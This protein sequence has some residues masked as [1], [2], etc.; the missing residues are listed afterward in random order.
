MT[1]SD[2]TRPNDLLLLAGKVLSLFMQAVTGFAAI[3]LAI[4]IPGIIIFQD[5]FAVEW[6]QEFPDATQAMPVWPLIGILLIVLALL[7]LVFFFFGKLRRIIGTVG[8]GDPFAP[9]NATRLTEM[10][11]L[12]LGTQILLV[13]AA[14]LALMLSKFAEEA[15][16]LDVTIDAGLDIEGILM[17]VILFILARVF[18]HGAAMRDDLEGTV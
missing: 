12:L 15:E 10:A 18:R 4:V 16:H 5:S 14:G 2:E 1:M 8:E 13:P 11:W 7:V 6:R 3:V 9:E 17:V